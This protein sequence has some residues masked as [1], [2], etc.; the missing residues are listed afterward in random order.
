MIPIKPFDT[1]K[2]RWLSVAPTESLL[3]PPVLLGVL[4][5][6]ARHEGKAQSSAEIAEELRKVQIDT[7]TPVN[8]ART[9]TRNLIRNSGQYWKG[10]GLLAPNRGEIHLTS[11]GQRVAAGNITQG[12]FAAIMVQQ[13]ILPNPWTYSPEEAAKWERAG[14]V[15]RPLAL[16]LAVIEEIALQTGDN[17]AAF[18]T[19][20]ELI[21][22]VIPLAGIKYLASLIAEYVINYRR[23]SLDLSRWPDCAPAANDHR[24]AREFLLFLSNFGFC[25]R[26]NAGLRLD[27]RYYLDELFDVS[28]LTPQT[29]ASI[30]TDETNREAV[31]NEVRHSPLPSII[32]RQRIMTTVLKRPNQAKFRDSTLKAYNT[33]CFLTGEEM[34]EVLEA[35]HIIPAAHGGNDKPDNGICLRVDIH[36]LFDSGNIRIKPTGDILLSEATA[37]STNY[38][39]LPSKIIIPTFVNPAHIQWRDSYL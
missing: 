8:L 18:L 19:A 26:V 28:A 1:Y 24:L 2:W 34:T 5:V 31:V 16:I 37:K 38:S 15:I 11:L 32:D 17:K 25:R 21:N 7:H 13:T 29:S 14:L 39:L 22:V 30:F 3:E 33:R 12:E 35:A 23:G 6:L 10:T 36:R 20:R 27:E 4:R 9:G